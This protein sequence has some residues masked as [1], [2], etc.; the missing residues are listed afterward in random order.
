MR[1]CV[2]LIAMFIGVTGHES[3]IEVEVFQDSGNC[4]NVSAF[5]RPASTT[6]QILTGICTPIF[7]GL[8]NLLVDYTCDSTKGITLAECDLQGTQG[9]SL[10]ATPDKNGCYPYV[11]VSFKIKNCSKSNAVYVNVV[12]AFYDTTNCTGTSQQNR[13]DDYGDDDPIRQDK[14]TLDSTTLPLKP[15]GACINITQGQGETPP[16]KAQMLTMDSC[17]ASTF[18]ISDCNGTNPKNYTR[19]NGT[20]TVGNTAVCF[21]NETDTKMQSYLIECAAAG[22]GRGLSGAGDGSSGSGMSTGEKTGIAVGGLVLIGVCV[23]LLTQ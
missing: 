18:T 10:T 12:D 23:L 20:G 5:N 14:S 6:V 1:G 4:S 19:V 22:S 11:D 8:P 7:P 21:K 9:T 15:S 3:L 17:D 13:G 2:V 16:W